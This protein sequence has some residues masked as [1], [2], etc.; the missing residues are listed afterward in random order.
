MEQEQTPAA[1]LDRLVSRSH[2]N[3]R[4][5]SRD[6]GHRRRAVATGQGFSYGP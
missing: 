2:E 5:E 1:Y 6:C 4:S 3:Q